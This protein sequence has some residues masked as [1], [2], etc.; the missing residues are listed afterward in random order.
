[1]NGASSTPWMADGF[2][3]FVSNGFVVVASQYR[4]ADGGE[5]KEEYG[6]A[7]IADVLNLIPL[8]KSLGYADMKNVFMFGNSRGGMM[9]YLALKNQTF[10]LM[11]RR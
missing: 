10:R 7:D 2:Y 4:G 1:M 6:G 5:G 8:A 3:E 11:R 9:T